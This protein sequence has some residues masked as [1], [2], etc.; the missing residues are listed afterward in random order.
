M[1]HDLKNKIDEEMVKKSKSTWRLIFIM[2]ICGWH[3]KIYLSIQLIC[4]Q[5]KETLSGKICANPR[6]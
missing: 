4:F 5:I 3:N 1:T 6:D 2:E